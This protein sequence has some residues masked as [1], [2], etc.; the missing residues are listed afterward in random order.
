MI[1]TKYVCLIIGILAASLIGQS[2]REIYRAAEARYFTQAD[3]ETFRFYG[4][5]RIEA[6][7][8]ILGNVIVAEGNLTVQGKITGD[9]IVIDGD[10]RLSGDAFVAGN[11]VCIDGRIY[12]TGRSEA[13]GY[14]LETNSKNLGRR[15]ENKWLQYD[16]YRFQHSNWENYSTLPLTPI[17]NKVLFRYN[18]VQGFFVGLN[19]PKSISKIGQSTSIHGFI[20]YGFSERKFRY[21]LGLDR[22]FFSRRE[23]R[24]EL[25][26]KFYDLTDTRDD[27]YITPLENTLSA[28]LFNSDYQDFY[29]RK[30]FEL[31]ASQNLTIFFKG[32]LI[33]KNDNYY[34]LATN[35]DWALFGKGKSFRENPEIIQGNM[36]SVTGELY[37]DTRNDRDFPFSGWYARLSMEVSN[38]KLNSDYYFNQYILDVR[39]YIPVSRTEQ[40]DFRIRAGSSEKLLPRQ[41]YFEMG[42]IGSMRGFGFK[43]FIGDRL[44]LGNLEYKVSLPGWQPMSDLRFIV[45]ADAGDAW[46]V[47]DNSDF[48]NGFRE[49]NVLKLKSDIGIAIADWKEHIRLNL[50]KRTDTGNDALVFTLRIAREF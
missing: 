7:D 46:F 38:D 44:L 16:H 36:R 42:G 19:F 37:F 31:H 14:L 32:S 6:D 2:N 39:N 3:F 23:Y 21:Q 25:G 22:S 43:E 41:K 4:H 40:I 47:E 27:W 8:Q 49:L 12:Q 34:S 11:I 48:R 17:A 33:Y 18:R 20:G 30:G 29:Q 35:T 13:S 24:F 28:V 10:I 9:I 45:F 50:A 5:T 1:K 26:G 15:S